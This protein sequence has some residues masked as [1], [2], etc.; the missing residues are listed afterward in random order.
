MRRLIV[1][2]A[3][4]YTSFLLNGLMTLK[5]RWQGPIGQL[6]SEDLRETCLPNGR[7]PH[8]PQEKTEQRPV[9]SNSEATKLRIFWASEMTNCTTFHGPP[10]RLSK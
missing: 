8:C 4:T 2:Y 5:N 1:R 3:I 9:P 7:C 10:L 6:F